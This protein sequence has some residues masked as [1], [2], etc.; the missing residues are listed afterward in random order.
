M[1]ETMS[2]EV[3]YALAEVQHLVRLEMAPGSTLEQA[4]R[5]SGLLQRCAEIDLAT[6]SFGIH[7][8]TKGLDTRLQPGDRVEIYRPLLVD[9]RQARRLRAAKKLP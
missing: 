7:G 4:L 2:V 9:P 3:V 6:N 5:A 8:Q 1:V